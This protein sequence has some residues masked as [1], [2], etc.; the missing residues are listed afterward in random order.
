MT[1]NNRSL[2]LGFLY[3]PTPV[4]PQ[5]GRTNYVDNSRIGS[6]LGLTQTWKIGKQSLSV[7]LSTSVQILLERSH[8]KR[9]DDH[10]PVVDEVP[11]SV[12]L[13]T[14][15]TIADS[16]GL[17]TNNPGFPGYSSDGFFALTGIN[18]KWVK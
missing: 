9:E 10:Q 3:A 4:P 2:Q 7:T 6:S 15:E 16:I 17:Q 14:R 1:Q 18:L 8:F 11:E 12:D 13:N 5:E